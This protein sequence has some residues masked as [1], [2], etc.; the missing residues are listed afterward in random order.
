MEKVIVLVRRADADDRWCERFR[1]PV[2]QRLLDLDL[3]GIS[4]G[5]KDADVRASLMTLTTLDPPVCA[6]VALWTQQHYGPPLRAA[7]DL[8]AA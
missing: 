4:V 6:V 2:A 8:L 1:G 5:V 7:L 3:P